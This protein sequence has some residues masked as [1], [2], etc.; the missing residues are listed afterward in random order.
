[1]GLKIT[2]SMTYARFQAMG[3]IFWAREFMVFTESAL[4]TAGTDRFIEEE[5]PK[6]YEWA[7]EINLLHKAKR[8]KAKLKFEKTVK[9]IKVK[10]RA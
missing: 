3:K 6:I 2:S 7:T 1:M 5:V 10:E 4:V 8:S 9:E